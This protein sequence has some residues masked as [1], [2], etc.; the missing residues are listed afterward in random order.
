MTRSRLLLWLFLTFTLD[1][2]EQPRARDTQA[3]RTD[4]SGGDTYDCESQPW[5]ADRDGD[6][7]GDPASSVEACSAPPGHVSDDTDCAPDDP[8]VHPDAEERCNAIDD[9]CDGAFDEDFDQ[10]DDGFLREDCAHVAEEDRDCDDDRSDVNPDAAE[11][12]DDGLDNDCDGQ[13]ARCG[14]D[15][16]YD[17]A[18]VDGKFHCADAGFDAGRLVDVGDVDGDGLDDFVATTLFAGTLDGG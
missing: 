13:D 14:F 15:A 9:D 4:D 5:Y 17:L 12:C 18:T 2:C 7:Y 8:S 1:A 3:P 6:G 16:S 10:D 11:I